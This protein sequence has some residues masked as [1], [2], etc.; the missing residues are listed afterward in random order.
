MVAD[1]VVMQP[2]VTDKLGNFR[3]V[4]DT[5]SV[6]CIQKSF[7]PFAIGQCARNII[8]LFNQ[9]AGDFFGQ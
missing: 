6:T 1:S 5:G 4:Q 8:R 2:G 7:D 3:T 9:T